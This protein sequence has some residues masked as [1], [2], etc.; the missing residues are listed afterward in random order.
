MVFT[1]ALPGGRNTSVI[2]IRLHSVFFS[3]QLCLYILFY[4]ISR[5]EKKHKF[6]TQPSIP[7]APSNTDEAGIRWPVCGVEWQTEAS[8][9]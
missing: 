3:F 8:S 2:R 4:K 1:W 7:V 9:E 5:T 6:L